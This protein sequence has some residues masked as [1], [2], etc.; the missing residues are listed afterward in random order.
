LDIDFGTYPYVTSSNPIAG[1]ALIGIGVSPLKVGKIYAIMKAYLTRV[2]E[3]PFP[4]ELTGEMGEYLREKGGEYGATT[5]RPRRCG[6]FDL[7]FAKYSQMLNGF[8]DI[9]FTKLDVLD[10]LDQIKVCV[11]YEVNGK[12]ID[13]FPFSNDTLY[14]VTPIYRDFPGWKS[15]GNVRRF[16]DLPQEAK[17]Y[18]LFI[19]DEL[20]APITIVSVGPDRDETIVR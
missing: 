13:R 3:G 6:W 16:E 18:I 10:G 17:N 9:V 14:N 1:G 15:T 7:V 19:E 2:G 8:T 4:T 5:G 20:K 11:G 12:K